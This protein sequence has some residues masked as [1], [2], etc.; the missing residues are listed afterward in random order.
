[1]STQKV[2]F[3]ILLLASTFLMLSSCERTSEADD[4]RNFT[5]DATSVSAF[6]GAEFSMVITNDGSLWGWGWYVPDL[7]GANAQSTLR[8]SHLPIYML[9]DVGSVS[10][11]LWHTAILTTDNVLWAWGDNTFGQLGDGST[12]H[13]HFLVHVMHDVAYVSAYRFQTFAIKT[14]GT[15]WAWGDNSSGQLGDG[16]TI[17]RHSPVRILNDVAAVSSSDRS[18]F[19]ISLDGTLWAWGKCFVGFRL[20]SAELFGYSPAPHVVID[21]NGFVP[22]YSALLGRWRLVASTA[23]DR[24]SYVSMRT[25]GL[26]FV[27]NAD[28]TLYIETVSRDLNWD[29]ITQEVLSWRLDSDGRLVIV[30]SD[31]DGVFDMVISRFSNSAGI[32]NSLTLLDVGFREEFLRMR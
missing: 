29:T 28:G 31:G 1:M 20:W 18:T 8:Y 2:I 24:E 16:T 6:P 30:N 22:R 32:G 10:F 12:R 7:L 3:I 26:D 13:R 11:G 27:F 19:A 14:D 21:Y 5:I 25:D 23:K 9:G 15:L 17:S 4:Y